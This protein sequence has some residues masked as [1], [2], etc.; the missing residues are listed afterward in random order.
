MTC[1]VAVRDR[2][3]VYIGGDS[4]GVGGWDL[5]VRKDPKVFT[6]STDH[7]EYA[8]GFTSSF[9]MGQL[10]AHSFT[11]P[12]CARGRDA[13]EYMATDF[14]NAVRDC[15]R[16]GGYARVSDNEET[17]GTFLVGFRGRLFQIESDFQVA[18]SRDP[19]MAVGCGG[20]YALGAFYAT[21]GEDPAARCLTALK[22]AER[23]SGGVRG[24]FRLVVIGRKETPKRKARK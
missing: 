6:L 16:D 5:T 11:P 2:G 24:P 14:V 22:A 23:H 10:L 20:A 19:F 12:R 8:L 9:R 17:G 21:K 13:W 4:A 7:D 3:T 18:E 15:L 1:I